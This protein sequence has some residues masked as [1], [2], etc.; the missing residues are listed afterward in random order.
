MPQVS[1]SH[2]VVIIETG[3]IPHS[4]TLLHQLPR[5][6]RHTPQVENS[7]AMIMINL[8]SS[9]FQARRPTVTV[10][11]VTVIGDPSRHLLELRT[12]LQRP[13]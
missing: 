6:A 12:E 7:S 11:S 1:A 13:S 4:S 5:V 2:D 9:P 3:S 10:T 8:I